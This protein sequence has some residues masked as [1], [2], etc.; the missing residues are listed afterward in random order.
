M[1]DEETTGIVSLLHEVV[2]FLN[3]AEI[4]LFEENLS[5]AWLEVGKGEVG[6]QRIRNDFLVLRFL[7]SENVGEVLIDDLLSFIFDSSELSDLA[8]LVIV[9]FFGEGFLDVEFEVAEGTEEP[10]F[11]SL[12]FFH[13]DYFWK[14]LFPIYLWNIFEYFSSFFYKSCYISYGKLDLETPPRPSRD[15][16]G[17]PPPRSP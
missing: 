11:S 5:D 3:F 12:D 4:K 2:S 13:I 14:P 9:T 16:E 1:E 17:L 7:L 8:S 6:Y 10:E 15:I